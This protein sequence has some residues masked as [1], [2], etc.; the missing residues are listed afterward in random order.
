MSGDPIVAGTDGSEAAELAVDRAGELA[1]ALDAP[2]HI[3]TVLERAAAPGL[4]EK[5]VANSRERLEGRGATVKTHVRTGDAASELIKVAEAEHAQMIVLGNRGMSGTARILGS[6]P[7][8][9]SH[10]ARCG[11]L[12][13]PT[14]L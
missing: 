9:V 12:I 2:V 10:H 7:N 11:V 4:A 1:Q 3:V 8:T 14:Q 13:I 5:L 6:V